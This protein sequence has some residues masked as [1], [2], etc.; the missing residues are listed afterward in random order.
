[1]RLSFE[2]EPQD[3]PRVEM[4]CVLRHGDKALT[5]TW[6]YQWAPTMGADRLPSRG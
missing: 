1:V 3:A 6:V 5:E 4:R 2:L